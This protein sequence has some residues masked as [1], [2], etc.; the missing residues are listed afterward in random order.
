MKVEPGHLLLIPH[1]FQ[2]YRK[3]NLRGPLI[4]VFSKFLKKIAVRWDGNDHDTPTS[5]VLPSE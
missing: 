4:Y 5:T 1:E 3:S 2:A